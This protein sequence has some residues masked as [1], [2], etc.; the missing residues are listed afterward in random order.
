[1][2]DTLQLRICARYDH[3]IL[4]KTLANLSKDNHEISSLIN[5]MMTPIPNER[6]GPDLLSTT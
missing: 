6:I 2:E 5:Q 1:A 4:T 3:N